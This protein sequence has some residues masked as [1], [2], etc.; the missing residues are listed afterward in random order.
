MINPKVSVICTCYNHEKFVV[1]AL[2][3]IISQTYSNIQIIVVD[4]CSTDNSQH[5]ISSWLQNYPDIKF[6]KN[7]L[8]LGCTKSFNNA[9]NYAEGDYLIDF[10]ADDILLDNCI[11]EQLKAFRESTFK[12]LA[13]VYGNI[14]LI[15]EN[16][17]LISI[18]YDNSQNP[19][20]GDIYK[21]VIGRTTKICSVA[22]MVKKSVFDTMGGYDEN[23]IYEDLDLWVRISRNYNFQYIP[24]ILAQKRELPNSLSSN[25]FTKGELSKQIH[26]STLVIFNKILNLNTSKKEYSIMLKRIKFESFKLIKA[27]EFYLFFKLIIIAFK[28]VF[29]SI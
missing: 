18:Y 13:I 16:K 5:V 6:I 8:N 21:M 27:K 20:S 14:N 22:S 28:A 4:D 25:F 2:N 29:K 19:E 24:K 9:I 15:D 11:E 7:A 3:S 17:N 12:N 1:E 10:A 23:L 26:K